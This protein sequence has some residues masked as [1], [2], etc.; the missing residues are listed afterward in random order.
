MSLQETSEIL[1]T[2]GLFAWIYDRLNNCLPF[3]A[4][5]DSEEGVRRMDRAEKARYQ[6]IVAF[7]RLVRSGIPGRDRLPIQRQSVLFS[8]WVRPETPTAGDLMLEELE[9]WILRIFVWRNRAVLEQQDCPDGDLGMAV[10]DAIGPIAETEPGHDNASMAWTKA[11]RIQF[12][13][14]IATCLIPASWCGPCAEAEEAALLA[15]MGSDSGSG[16]DGDDSI[17]LEAETAFTQVSPG[18]EGSVGEYDLYITNANINTALL[19]ANPNVPDDAIVLA[20]ATCTLILNFS[21]LYAAMESVC[22]ETDFWHL[23]GIMDEAHRITL[24]PNL[25]IAK[26]SA[27]LG[28]RLATKLLE[29]INPYFD[30]IFADEEQANIPDHYWNL[31]KTAGGADAVSDADRPYWD[32]Q[33]DASHISFLDTFKNGVG[34]SKAFVANSALATRL[35]WDGLASEPAHITLAGE[36]AARAAFEQQAAYWEASPV[37]FGTRPLNIAFGFPSLQTPGVIMLGVGL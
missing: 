27:S 19:E 31:I 36:A 3:R 2:P 10:M 15:S 26:P 23:G 30:G 16:S 17:A 1:G 37:R 6:R 13:V 11:F 28:K 25:Y 8:L 5:L 12:L 21:G 7:G 20:Y 34:S 35:K 9:D 18:Q 22:F 32:L 4:L 14:N 29:V 24:E 33:H